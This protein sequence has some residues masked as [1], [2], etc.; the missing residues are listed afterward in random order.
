MGEAKNSFICLI[1][2]FLSTSMKFAS[3]RTPRKSS[4]RRSS[5]A[6]QEGR[7]RQH[8]SAFECGGV[9]SKAISK[10]SSVAPLKNVKNLISKL[11][12][13]LIM[14][15]SEQKNN[16]LSSMGSTGAATMAAANLVRPSKFRH[17]Y[18]LV[19]AA[20]S[21]LIDGVVFPLN[22]KP[23]FDL[24]A[25]FC[26]VAF[27]HKY[28]VFPWTPSSSSSSADAAAFT[29]TM[30][31]SSSS[32]SSSMN[33][34]VAVGTFDGVKLLDLK[35]N[36]HRSSELAFSGTGGSVQ[37][38]RVDGDEQQQ[39]QQLCLTKTAHL[40]HTKDVHLVDW[41]PIVGDYLLSISSPDHKV[42]LWSADGRQ[43][44]QLAHPDL[45]GGVSWSADGSSLTTPCRDG[46]VRFFVDGDLRWT[47]DSAA[48][49]V[50]VRQFRPHAA[51]YK[52]CQ[53][54][55]LKDGRVFTSG[56]TKSSMREIALWEVSTTSTSSSLE[57]TSVSST[58][59]SVSST[60][61]SVSSTSS[62]VSSEEP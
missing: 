5:M 14:T 40:Q 12:T 62:S 8:I 11:E 18:C 54:T 58:S 33:A 56:S 53:A 32:S 41:H 61:S 24:N 16:F 46:F 22:E 28:F 21:L 20:D 43:V 2:S 1:K 60:S 13:G 45:V 49:A 51:V 6:V 42:V 35:W 47:S 37:I 31:S 9:K 44:W 3:A 10:S 39:Q 36:P 19:S 30:P 55:I 48:E 50:A 52:L 17:I 38:W 34:A 15:N 23:I 29:R 27:R 59:S 7:V 26:A 57:S 25:C 4:S